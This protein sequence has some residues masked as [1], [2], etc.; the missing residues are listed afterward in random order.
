MA[1]HRLGGA[2]VG[3]HLPVL[4]VDEKQMSR[5]GVRVVVMMKRVAVGKAEG[6]FEQ[7]LQ[8]GSGAGRGGTS[9]RRAGSSWC[10]YQIRG[11]RQM[12]AGTCWWRGRRSGR[13]SW[14]GQTTEDTK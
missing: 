7:A 10:A 4:V 13:K 9:T 8:W 14:M 11:C 6:G 2:V 1:G 12:V 3:W 5:N